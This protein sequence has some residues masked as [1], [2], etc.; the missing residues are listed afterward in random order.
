MTSTHSAVFYR[1]DADY[2]RALVPFVVEGLA[3]DE[4]VAVAVPEPRL[5]LLRDA[6][7]ADADRVT[8]I[9][10]YR[11]GRNP[12]RIIPTVLHRFA[13][14]HPDRHVRIIGGPVWAGR[15]PTEY[16]ACAQHEALINLVFTGRRVTI[17]C[18]YDS[19]GLDPL[20]VADARRT[21]PQLWDGHHRL[22]SPD[23]DPHAVINAYNRALTFDNATAMRFRV[24]ST[25]G[26]RAA[27]TWATTHAERIGLGPARVA[28]LELIVS[29]LTTNSLLHGGGDCL[30]ALHDH[31]GHLVCEVADAGHLANPLAGYLPATPGSLGG[32]G[33]LLVHQLADLVHTHRTPR[34]TTQYAFLALPAAT[35]D[36]SPA[37]AT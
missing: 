18:P 10:M 11:A 24:A 9:D 5:R 35:T 17:A 2:L 15:T 37:P 8:F 32:H 6:L 23:Y 13:D 4:P 3:A 20:V 33:L 21:H 28:D 26:I 7:G 36:R 14:S 1:T 29:E 30:L 16:P 19:A 12:G 34:G 31:N 27:R 25:G 22:A